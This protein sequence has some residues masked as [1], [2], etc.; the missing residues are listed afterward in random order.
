[1]SFIIPFIILLILSYGHI[2]GAK[3]YDAFVEGARDGLMI[4]VRILPYIAAMLLA[5]GMLRNSGG[6]DFLL[7][8]LSPATTAAGIPAEVVPLIIMK[9]L[10]GSGA[11]G[12][13]ADI[14]K[15]SGADSHAGVL[16]SIIMSSTETIFYTITVY[17]GSVGIKNIRHTLAAA[18]VAD[19]AGLAAAVTICRI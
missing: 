10:S 9:P 17:F 8:I 19:M 1:M 4:T 6:L 13:L 18:I 16:A 14:L 7:Y 2:R 3:V 11:L 12:I 15:R 5:V